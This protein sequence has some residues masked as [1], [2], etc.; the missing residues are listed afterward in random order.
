MLKP[1]ARLGGILLAA[2][3]IH[4]LAIDIPKPLEEWKPW[5]LEKHQDLNCPVAHNNNQRSCIWPTTLRIDAK[6]TG[7][8]FSFHLEVYKSDW[9]SL[10]G[11]ASFWPQHLL[12]NNIP[13]AVRDQDDNPEVF[14]TAGSHELSGDISWEDMPRSLTIPEETGLIDLSVN[15]HK[16]NNPERQDTNKLWLAASEKT[17]AAAHQDSLNVK[18]F[19]RVGDGI[20]LMLTTEI[21]LDVSGKEREITLGQLLLDG[22][23]PISFSSELP[24]RLEKDGSLRIQVKPGSWSVTLESQITAPAKQLHYSQTS[25]QWPDQEIWVFAAAPS[26]RSVQISGA[27]AIDPQQSQLPDDWKNLPAYLVTPGTQF[28]LEELRRGEARELG[29]ELRLERTSWLAFDGSHFINRDEITGSTHEYRLETRAPLELTSATIDGKPQ[30][31]TH[32]A[33]SSNS[34]LEIRSRNIDL[35][36]ISQWV[37]SLQLPVSGWNL[38]FKRVS[39]S[40]YLPPGW[41][42]LTATGTSRENGSW[43]SAWSL[44]DMFLVFV[45][46][47]AVTR[48]CNPALGALT[49]ITLIIIYQREAAPVMIWL[50]ILAVIAL[51]RW[52]SGAMKSWA[53]RYGWISFFLLILQTLPFSVHEMRAAINPTL[54]NESVFS[55]FNPHYSSV[56]LADR[57]SSPAPDKLP[58]ILETKVVEEQATEEEVIV[59]GLKGKQKADS[60]QRA[61]GIPISKRYDPNQQTQTGVA[62]PDWHHNHA[63]L[64]W[65]GPI[66]ANETTRLWLVSPWLNCIGYIASALLPLLL[67]GLLLLRFLQHQG[68]NLA[69]PTW[70]TPASTA[71]P[72]LLCALAFG[73]SDQT[74]ADVTID[75]A[76]LK[77]LEQRLTEAPRCLPACAAIESLSVNLKDDLMTLNMQVHSSELIALPIPA[78]AEQWWPNQVTVDGRNAALVTANKKLLVSLPK[79]RH[80]LEIKAAVQ[81]LDNL[82][83]EFPTALHHVTSYLSNWDISG[84]PTD[85]QTSKSLQLQRVERSNVQAERLRPDPINAFV[86]VHRE[87]SLDLEW[88][89]KTQV[90]R[91][92]PESGTINL[93]V[94]LLDGEMPLSL[95]VNDNKKVAVHLEAN[96]QSFE[97]TSSLKAVNP[98]HLQAAEQV[99]WIEIWSLDVSHLWHIETQGIPAIESAKAVPVWQPWPGES[100]NIAVTRPAAMKGDYVTIDEAHLQ[101]NQEERVN[102]SELQLTIRANQGSQYNFTLPEQAHLKALTIDGRPLI[103]SSTNNQLKIP[104]HPGQQY[105]SIAWDSDEKFSL[106]TRS[107]KFALDKGSSNQHINIDVPQNRWI[108]WV[109]GPQMGPSVLLWGML[110]IALLLSYAIG[111]TGLTPLRSYEWILLSLGVCTQGFF[112]LVIIAIWFV[113]LHQRGKLTQMATAKRFKWMQAGLFVFSLIALGL[114][115]STIPEGLLGQPDMRILGNQSY[116]NH[117]NWYQDNSPADF[118]RAWFISLPLWCYKLAIL[119]WALWMASALIRWLRWAWQQLSAQ[120]LWYLP[121]SCL[122]K[123]PAPTPTAD[124]LTL[125]EDIF[126][127]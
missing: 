55:Y 10:P 60:L 63:N 122:T 90:T 57:V 52:T 9:V 104:L 1:V 48:M 25:P 18:V 53:V 82:N 103:I 120:A 19:R 15:G 64:F 84:L 58:E 22:F 31:I 42:L 24:A 87:V 37:R 46:A 108:L 36:G 125:D 62:E 56:R 21:A 68:V 113:V 43:V 17:N 96:Q 81:G 29:N 41:S 51:T 83:L 97:W 80:T 79:G 54:E 121:E 65:E 39:T 38:E 118:P 50:N 49:A 102:H 30:L 20:P 95:Q 111:R 6:Q 14:L 69:L 44:W 59:T 12:D 93:E 105:I 8:N 32:L 61:P 28:T 78:D 110:I 33:N 112:T 89:V 71:V 91:V 66:N 114:L 101:F 98:L 106:F 4:S 3:S 45:I 73:H 117:L 123:T 23:T 100:L 11:D 67:A 2:L 75:P 124:T 35:T 13:I 74:Q 47:V 77:E 40:L 115:I 34:G 88:T 92:A 116:S 99:P 70:R 94:P 7:A 72:L 86:I 26:L 5:V 127:K 119:A 76:L 27:Q 107:P 126:K 16:I 85:E 109:G